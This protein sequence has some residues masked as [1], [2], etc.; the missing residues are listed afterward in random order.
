MHAYPMRRAINR[1]LQSILRSAEPGLLNDFLAAWSATERIPADLTPLLM[2]VLAMPDKSAI[3]ARIGWMNRVGIAAPI[4]V[5]VQGDPRRQ[6]RCRIF[7]EEGEPRI[8]N[9]EYWL[10][11]EYSGHRRAYA[12]YVHSLARTL[13]LPQLLKGLRAEAEFAEAYPNRSERRKRM[14]SMTW[15]ELCATYTTVDWA[16]LLT[17]WGLKES[18]LAVATFMVSSSPFLHRMQSRMR[19]W[20]MER[21]QGWFALLV[22]Q[23]FAGITPHGPL[24]RAWFAYNMRFR[25]GMQTDVTPNELRLEVART[26]LPNTLGQLW[27]RDH[28]APELKRTIRAM[29]ERIRTAAIQRMSAVSWMAPSSRAMAVAKLRG[30]DMQVC[31]PDRWESLDLTA[32]SRD[33]L[34]EFILQINAAS[35]DMMLRSLRAG[36]CS[37]P[38]GDGWGAPVFEVNAFYYPSENRL[39]IPAGIL[40]PPFYD[41]RKS[42]LWNYGAIGT[43][44]GHEICHAFDAEGRNYDAS[45]NQRNWWT[46]GDVKEYDALARA[47]V[48]LYESEEYRGLAVDGK[49]TLVE[50]IADLGGVEFA[51][52]AAAADRRLTNAE[53]RE[54]FHSYAYSW[55]S[56]ERMRTAAER[57]INDTHAP[58]KL[59]VNHTLRQLDEWYEAFEV[60]PKCAAFVPPE[61][62]VRFFR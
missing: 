47:M 49:L 34:V 53:I 29:C 3:S 58:P 33:S 55:R 36:D 11:P 42:A 59:R 61:R 62:R 8:G 22:V 16:T 17:A 23:A 32:G 7:I 50:N 18:E 2:G 48:A 38:Y 13:G 19:S 6:E 1:E 26:A 15:H 5:S 40:K 57:L 12:A 54:F 45:G 4:L 31:W 25:Y 43:T 37:K 44:I 20:S 39:L 24:R 9:P 21:W 10:Q 51:L 46:S 27:V 52:A 60:G 35:T 14:N 28:C 56:K 41:P 30:L